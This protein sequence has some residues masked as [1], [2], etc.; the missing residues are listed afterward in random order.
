MAR[1]RGAQ[2]SSPSSRKRVAPQTPVQGSTSK[3]PRHLTS[4]LQLRRTNESPV[5]RYHTGQV[6]SHPRRKLSPSSGTPSIAPEVSYGTIAYSKGFLLSPCGNG[7]LSIH[8]HTPCP[9]PTLI[10][11]TI[12]GR[13]GASTGQY[14]QRKELPPSM[15]FIDALLRHNIFPLQHWVQRRGVLLGHYI[16]YLRDSSLALIIS[17]WS[18]FYILKKRSIRRSCSELMPFLYCSPDCYVRFWN[19]WATQLSL[20]LSANGFFERYSL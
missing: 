9:E 20:N 5:R 6:T 11:F 10:H 2:F 15:F 4:H 7:F 12:D 16:G 3:P 8:D 13:H 19:T 1:T 17:L 18:S 14:L